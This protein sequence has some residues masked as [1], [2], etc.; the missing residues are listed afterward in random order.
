MLFVTWPGMLVALI[1]IVLIEAWILKAKLEVTFGEAVRLGVI[2]NL[3]STIIGIPLAWLTLVGIELVAT[4]GGMA[5]GLDTPWR[6]VLA[7]TIQAPWLIP[8]ESDLYWMVPAATLVLLPAYFLASW[9]IEYAVIRKL[10]RV[11]EPSI[12]EPKP[13]DN[14]ARFVR[15][16]SFVANLASYG[17]LAL[18]TLVWLGIAIVR[19]PQQRASE[20]RIVSPPTS[21]RVDASPTVSSTSKPRLRIEFENP[22]RQNLTIDVRI[23]AGRC[24]SNPIVRSHQ[25]KGD[26]GYVFTGF[27][28]PDEV[29]CYAVRGP[30]TTSGE[31]LGAWQTIS[32]TVKPDQQSEAYHAIIP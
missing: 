17:L 19:G 22:T 12:F 13:L 5:F 31:H 16:A 20:A 6:K 1:P 2:A 24:G 4:S 21:N 11:P 18:F 25:I 7:V 15:N 23:G 30:E 8:Y 10:L 3:A 14:P 28:E 26:A 29:A 32:R 27:I 9:G